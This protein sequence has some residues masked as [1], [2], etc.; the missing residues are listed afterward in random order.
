[1]VQYVSAFALAPATFVL[2]PL[3]TFATIVVYPV[4]FLFLCAA[5]VASYI[6]RAVVSRD[7][8]ASAEPS[9]LLIR[10]GSQGFGKWMTKASKEYSQGYSVINWVSV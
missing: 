10:T 6:L 7:R 1:M 2:D 8:R 3:S 9:S 4:V 5:V